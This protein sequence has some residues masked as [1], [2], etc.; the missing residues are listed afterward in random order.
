MKHSKI[1]KQLFAAIVL[2]LG[3]FYNMQ[4]A[5]AYSVWADVETRG[6]VQGSTD[7]TLPEASD[8]NTAEPMFYVEPGHDTDP[9]IRQAPQ[10]HSGKQQDSHA[11][12]LQ[13]VDNLQAELQQLRGKLEEQEHQIMQLQAQQRKLYADIDERLAALSGQTARSDEV[14]VE[15]QANPQATASAAQPDLHEAPELYQQ[16]YTKVR[17]KRYSDAR[18]LFE[19]LLKRYPKSSLAPNAHYW[20]GEL[21]LLDNDNESART[22]FAV[23][24]REFPKHHK[25]ADALLKLGLMDLFDGKADAADRYFR[26]V[27]EQF[28][29]SASA[30]VAKQQLH[31]MRQGS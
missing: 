16:A 29:Q 18:Q 11:D 21:Y 15:T 23:I 20:L 14:A 30:K 6:P 28:P 5:L 7:A 1:F 2:G 19:E 24:V 12:V 25:A 26:Q 9:N 8:P 31:K 10:A 13:A 4:A 3:S 17:E 27:I 22:A